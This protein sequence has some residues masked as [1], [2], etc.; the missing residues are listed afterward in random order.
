MSFFFAKIKFYLLIEKRD[1]VFSF[2]YFERKNKEEINKI[3]HRIKGNVISNGSHH[4]VNKP[5]VESTRHPM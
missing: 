3:K 1:E 2:S 5:T 4:R